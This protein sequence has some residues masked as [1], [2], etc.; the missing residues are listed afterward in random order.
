MKTMMLVLGLVA[1]LWLVY[2]AKLHSVT[3]EFPICKQVN[4]T[5]QD[6]TRCYQT[7]W[8]WHSAI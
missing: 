6:K 8:W 3:S 4:Q 7:Q 5:Q 2:A 1:I